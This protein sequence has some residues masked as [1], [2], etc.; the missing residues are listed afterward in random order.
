MTIWIIL[1]PDHPSSREHIGIDRWLQVG[2][3]VAI[4][5]GL[6]LVGFQMKQSSDLQKMQIIRDDTAAY[7]A[8]EMGSIGENFSAVWAKSM[9]SPDSLSLEELRIIDSYLYANYVY[10]WMGNFQRYRRRV[11]DR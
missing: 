9:E 8:N 10:R 4:L 5:A 2:A 7:M 11:L 3:N 6:V 1:L